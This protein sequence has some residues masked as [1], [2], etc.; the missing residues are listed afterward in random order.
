M[1]LGDTDDGRMSRVVGGV[2]QQEAGAH[3]RASAMEPQRRAPYFSAKPTPRS[4]SAAKLPVAES[5][6]PTWSM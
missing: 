5:S 2:K 3:Q 1:I 4:S 6:G